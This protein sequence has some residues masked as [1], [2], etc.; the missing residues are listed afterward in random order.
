MTGNWLSL[1]R[2]LDERLSGQAARTAANQETVAVKVA[3]LDESAANF[4]EKIVSFMRKIR[5]DFRST[6]E[7]LEAIIEDKI[8]LV[9]EDGRSQCGE[10]V[11]RQA[12]E[13]RRIDDRIDSLERWVL[14]NEFLDSLLHLQTSLLFIKTKS[15]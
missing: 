1:P 10:L 2:A 4:D 9:V 7:E 12:A 5:G 14:F 3:A 13:N 8:Q 11:A 6:K 15:F